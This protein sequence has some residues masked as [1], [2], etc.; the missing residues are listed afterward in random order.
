MV[1]GM[2]QLSFRGNYS[3]AHKK[4]TEIDSYLWSP[5]QHS[6]VQKYTG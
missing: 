5:N 4:K 1:C 6:L 2:V 3:F